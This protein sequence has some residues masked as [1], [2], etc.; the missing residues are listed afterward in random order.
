MMKNQTVTISYFQLKQELCD[1]FTQKCLF[2]KKIAFE[3][4]MTTPWCVANFWQQCFC[5]PRISAG[6]AINSYLWIQNLSQLSFTACTKE[7]IC[8][9][10][11]LYQHCG[12]STQGKEKTNNHDVLDLNSMLSS[13]D[14]AFDIELLKECSNLLLIGATPF[15]RYAS[16]YNRR[17]G[18]N[19]T[20]R[21][22]Q[23][24]TTVKRMKW[25]VILC[26]VIHYLFI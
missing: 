24:N 7:L 4:S 16:S 10:C 6:T 2:L 9:K 22:E 26:L 21:S 19:K 12:C 25:Y 15:S 11:K 14:T 17:F 8:Q 1:S 18:Y 20:E 5:H 3:S 13:E 23:Y